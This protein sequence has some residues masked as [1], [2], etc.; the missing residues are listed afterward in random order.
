MF[1]VFTAGKS[2][3]SV[4]LNLL[5]SGIQH[6]PK[7]TPPFTPHLKKEREKKKKCPVNWLP[8]TCRLYFQYLLVAVLTASAD[9][10]K[11]YEQ[12]LAPD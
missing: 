6:F 1:F 11:R 5:S 12:V 10:S 3:A 7:P 8:Q 2:E 4:G 9:Y